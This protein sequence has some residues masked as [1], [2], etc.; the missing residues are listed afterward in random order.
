MNKYN[1]EEYEALECCEI[2]KSLLDDV[3]FNSNIPIINLLNQYGI[4]KEDFFVK[5]ILIVPELFYAK[6]DIR[7]HK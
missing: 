7:K 2:L 4:T 5:K 1:S 3:N 6:E